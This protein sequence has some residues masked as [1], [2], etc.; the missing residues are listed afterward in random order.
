MMGAMEVLPSISI[1]S[2]FFARPVFLPHEKTQH[3]P[4]V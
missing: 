2:A 1:G 3:L 4:E